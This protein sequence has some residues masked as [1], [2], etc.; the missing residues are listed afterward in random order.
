MNV[1]QKGMKFIYAV[2]HPSTQLNLPIAFPIPERTFQNRLGRK[3]KT[4]AAGG[5][6]QPLRS[7]LDPALA[8]EIM[9]FCIDPPALV[10]GDDLLKLIILQVKS[11]ES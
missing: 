10:L 9:P 3:A 11:D 2:T 7:H 8:A 4:V 5:P 1:F 6:A